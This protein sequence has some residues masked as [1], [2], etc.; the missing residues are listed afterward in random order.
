MTRLVWGAGASFFLAA[1]IFVACSSDKSTSQGSSQVSKRGESCQS[2]GDCETGFICVRNVCSVGSYNLT[3]TGKQCF[4]VDCHAPEDC[5]PPPSPNCAILQADCEAGFTFECQSY[6]AQCVC[7]A[8]KFSC[9]QGK[10]VQSC[11]P[12]DGGIGSFDSCRLFGSTFSCVGGKCV[13]CTKDADCMS[14]DGKQRICKD[15]KCQGKCDKDSDCDPFF[16]CDLGTAAC[17]YVGCQTHLECVAKTGN[18]LAVCENMK[19]GVPCKSDPECG[20]TTGV[21]GLE[22]VALGLQVCIDAHCVDVGCDSD[23]Q[24]R[25]L[26][27][28][29]G[30]SRTTA[31]CRAPAM[32]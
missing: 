17:V 24:C 13:E 11:T 30:G 20:V 2:S 3:P 15:N 31:E 25:I 21:G 7:D 16:R 10:C 5:C 4:L 32:P 19:C 22:G 23:D 6:Q 26:N 14:F 8:T 28:I 12:S 27:H 18:P 9:D 1:A 29:Q